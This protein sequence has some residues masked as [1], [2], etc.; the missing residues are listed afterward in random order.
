M[1]KNKLELAIPMLRTF[2]KYP[3]RNP[4]HMK[5]SKCHSSTTQTAIMPHKMGSVSN[6]NGFK[7]TITQSYNLRERLK[8]TLGEPQAT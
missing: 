4:G 8:Y 7:E 2:K 5:N 3:S 1:K 6:G